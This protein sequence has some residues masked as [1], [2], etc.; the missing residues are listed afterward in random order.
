[1]HRTTRHLLCFYAI[2]AIVYGAVLCF[3]WSQC[4]DYDDICR[5]VRGDGARFGL[6]V[7][8]AGVGTL[9]WAGS[10][11]DSEA[12]AARQAQQT[13]SAEQ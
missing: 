13:D 4:G 8:F 12:A 3:Q 10:A 6:F 7:I 1:M 9:I 2:L 5:A 11:N